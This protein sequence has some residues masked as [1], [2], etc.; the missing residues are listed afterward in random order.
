[1]RRTSDMRAQL[2]VVPSPEASPPGADDAVR[3]L[4]ATIRE[5][6]AENLN[7]R[8]ALDSRIVIEQAKGV[9]AERFATTPDTAFAALRT[10]ARSSRV[11]L[12]DLAR[13]VVSSRATPPA[14]AREFARRSD[15]GDAA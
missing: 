11:R 2:T 7:L 12:H 3:R 15:T 8:T 13:E 14:V 10:G 5:L 4:V 6:R 1:M 9:L